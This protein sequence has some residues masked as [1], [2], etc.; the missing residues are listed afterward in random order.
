MRFIRTPK[1][2]NPEYLENFPHVGCLDN[3]TYAEDALESVDEM[4]EP[5]GFEVI[6]YNRREDDWYYEIRKRTAK[7]AKSS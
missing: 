1:G 4:L 2:F 7:A 3:K 5:L 6:V